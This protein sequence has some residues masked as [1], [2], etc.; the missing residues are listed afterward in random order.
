MSGG[1]QLRDYLKVEDVAE[2]I[3]K[4]ILQDNILG[5]IN[6][7]S[8]KPISI[9]TLVENYISK[10]KSDIKLNLAYYDYPKYEP[11]AFWGSTYKLQQIIKLSNYE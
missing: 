8:G 10:K 3:L 9:R 4:I 5:I 11:F 1:E 2:Y 6:L 7:C